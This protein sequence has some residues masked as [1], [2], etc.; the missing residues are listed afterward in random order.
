MRPS[1]TGCRPRDH[2]HQRGLARAI[3]ADE[4]QNLAGGDGQGQA[5]DRLQLSMAARWPDGQA[6][7]GSFRA[8]PQIGALHCGMGHHIARIAFGQH[9]ALGHA[10]QP[11][12]DRKSA[13]RMC[14]IQTTVMPSAC[15]GGSGPPVRSSS[16]RSTRRRS[17]PAGSPRPR[18]Q[19]AGQFQP[20]AVQKAQRRGGAVGQRQKAGPAQDLAPCS[21][22]CGL[23]KPAP[24]MAATWTFSNTVMPRNGRGT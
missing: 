13:C 4:G 23:V 10:D 9:P 16:P 8:A 5:L 11:R 12:H 6:S 14:S 1:A 3:R 2:P 17:H 22:A 15:S 24:D 7:E 20:L 18:R 21:A 19:R